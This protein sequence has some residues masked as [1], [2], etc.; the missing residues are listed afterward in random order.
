M[1]ASPT[2]TFYLFTNCQ[3]SF[4]FLCHSL[5]LCLSLSLNPSLRFLFLLYHYP[6]L[7]GISPK[8]NYQVSSEIAKRSAFSLIF[9]ATGSYQ[10]NE[11]DIPALVQKIPA[12][13]YKYFIRKKN[14]SGAVVEK[15]KKSKG[16][17]RTIKLMNTFPF[18]ILIGEGGPVYFI[19]IVLRG[20]KAIR[21]HKITHLYSS[22]RPFTDHFAAF[23]LK[24]MH[25]Q[26]FWVADFRD[27]MVDPY[28]NKLYFDK[29]H[30][31]LFKRIFKK[32]DVLTTVSDGLAKHLMLYNHNVITLKN[33]ILNFPVDFS[34]VVCPLFTIAYTGSMYLDKK[35][36]R[37]LFV[38]VK[39]LTD[40]GKIIKEKINIIY[41]GKDAF[42]WNEMA[43]AFDLMSILDI[44]GNLSSDDAMVIQKNACINLLLSIS[45][46]ELTGILTGKMIEYF[47]TGSPILAIVTNQIDP[48]LESILHEL[49][50]GKSFSDQTSDLVGIKKFILEEYLRWEKTGTNRKPVDFELLKSK[51]A[52]E[53]TMR[54]LFEFLLGH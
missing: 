45:S 27:L 16:I 31:K 4:F 26:I 54:P 20:N 47:E 2:T 3:L 36:A 21:K 44:R 37:P 29:L 39:E 53:E 9:T 33:G 28:F 38:A 41:A 32:A 30:L 7:P 23:I 24:T 1:G 43:Q 52:V 34:P 40:E 22:F 15:N 17:Q 50:I 49:Q 8:R 6:P 25:P 10:V 12:F 5:R 42:Y 19:N 51:Y 35:N 11:T 46:D 13:D 48:E 18:T 14:V